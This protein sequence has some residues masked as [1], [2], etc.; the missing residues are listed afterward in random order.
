VVRACSSLAEDPSLITSTPFGQLTTACNSISADSISHTHT[1]KN[2]Q[3]I[4]IFKG[5]FLIYI[6]K[7]LK[8]FFFQPLLDF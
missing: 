2:I 6:L 5:F 7:K 8:I 3:V 1:H 4:L